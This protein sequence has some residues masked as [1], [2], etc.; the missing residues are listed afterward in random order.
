MFGL[1]L[2]LAVLLN[3]SR[4]DA[5]IPDIRLTVTDN[6]I[7]LRFDPD[8]LEANLLTVADLKREC[9]LLKPVGYAL[10]FG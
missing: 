10:T 7:D 3:R 9:H 5:E 1:L 2:W 8:W 4:R 6:S